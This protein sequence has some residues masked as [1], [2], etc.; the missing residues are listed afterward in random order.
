MAAMTHEPWFEL[1]SAAADDELV[2]D[3]SARLAEHLATCTGCADLL[4]RMEH[5]R[6]VARLH[7]PDAGAPLVTTV[8]AARTAERADE[9]RAQRRLVRRAGVAAT[10]VA[11]AMI[12]VVSLAR[13]AAGPPPPPQ[14]PLADNEVLIDAWGRTFEHADVE[15]AA[16]TTVEWRN[17]GADRH[18]LVRSL[19]GATIT[20]DLLPGH[21]ESARFSEPGVYRFYCT[22][23]PE[24]TGTVTVDA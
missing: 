18:H 14:P 24:M 6:R 12:A 11:A 13:P 3:E 7:R 1:I 8:L 5:D 17:A 16:G 2:G 20:E 21:T 9:R 10:A 19:G 4:A 23:H 22:I 15:V